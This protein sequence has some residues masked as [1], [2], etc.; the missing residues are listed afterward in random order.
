MVGEEVK[1]NLVGTTAC[2]EYGYKADAAV[3]CEPSCGDDRPFQ[4][5]TC[6]GGVA[7][8]R[9]AVKGKGCHI[10][11]RK[12]VIRDGGLGSQVGVNAI[13]KGFIIYNAV[14]E[15]ERQWGQTKRHDMFEPGQFVINDGIVQGGIAKS[16]VAPEMTLDYA[17]LFPPQ[18]TFEEIKEEIEKCIYN[19]CQ[20]DPW[21]RENPPEITWLFDWPA[22]EVGQDIPIAKTVQKAVREVVPEGG[23]MTSMKAVC[24]AP[25]VTEQ[26]IPAVIL[27]PGNFK[28]A[29]TEGEKIEIQRM[30]EAAKIYALAMAEWCQTE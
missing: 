1:D 17:V 15:L 10:G 18:N 16:T 19:A 26:G 4:I 30:V 24:D 21:L 3:V 12:E 28:Y 25:F 2:I 11:V 8:F 7:E 6:T 20:N 29:H 22:F 23:E 13:D 27:G 14:R 9:V 5:H